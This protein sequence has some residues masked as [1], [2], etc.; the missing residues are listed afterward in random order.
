MDPENDSL[1]KLKKQ[2]K[3]ALESDSGDDEYEALIAAAEYLGV[4]WDPD[5]AFLKE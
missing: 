4:E 5:A 2:I 1:K 3:D